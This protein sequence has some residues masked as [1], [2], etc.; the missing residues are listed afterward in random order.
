MLMTAATVAVL[1]Q[2]A[3]CD[4][5]SRPEEPA[6]EVPTE[7]APPDT[8]PNFAGTVSDQNYT[9]GDE[10]KPLTLP[11]ASGGNGSLSYSLT[12]TVPGLLFVQ[13]TRTLGGTPTSSGSYVMTYRSVDGDDNTAEDD[14]AVLMF[15]I[16]VRESTPPDTAPSFGVQTVSDQT[17]TAGTQIDALVLPE[18][19]GGNGSLSYSL[20]PTVPGLLFVQATRTLSGTPTSSGSYVMTYRSVDGDDNTA[21]DDTAVLMF[22]IVVRESTP[23]DTAP[24]FGVQTV[25]DQTYTA[26][27]Q[28]DAL[29]LPEASGGNGSLSYSLTPTVPGLLFVQATRTLS[30]TP[31]S[32]GSYVMTYR[33]VDG[34]DN[35][36]EDDT[37]VLMFMIVVRES[38]PPDTA[39]SFGVQTVSDQ[40]YTAGTQIDALVL[41]EASGGNG[42]LTYSLNTS[43]VPDLVFNK[44][45]RM[46]TGRPIAVGTYAM[47]YR[48]EDADGDAATLNFG[49]TVDAGS[50]P[51]I[52]WTNIWG[53]RISRSNLD[54]SGIEVLIDS[55][56]NVRDPSWI[57]LDVEGGKMYWV[58]SASRGDKVQR[59]NLD[60]SDVEDL[61]QLEHA[62][63]I[64]LD[65]A[66][67]KMYWTAHTKIQRANLDGS[68]VE[69]VVARGGND[70]QGIALDTTSGKMYWTDSSSNKIRRANIDGSGLE[71]LAD[72]DD[73]GGLIWGID[74]DADS[75]KMYW[76]DRYDSV[77]ERANLDGSNVETLVVFPDYDALYPTAIA[78]DVAA[79]K[80]YFAESSRKIQ[81]ANLDGSQLEDVLTQDRFY[82]FALD[83]RDR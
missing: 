42:P 11:A 52:Y 35:T 83:L 4:E 63:G 58:S 17:Y 20:T 62:D 6:R 40:T 60:G 47:R 46:L 72:F 39:P 44:L 36:A 55:D 56:R 65:I 70:L 9:V 78:L 21:E 71:V 8:A 29:V 74:I 31:T 61:V 10:I 64:T 32:S 30:G 16:V 25:S 43:A 28:I 79:E 67:G 77:V 49:I 75:G 80:M 69:D 23:P 45:T 59:A 51:K 38:T 7:P 13:A 68:H 18:A 81:R 76:T 3:A 48:V 66:R 22:M 12:P 2:L 24:S 57:A 82:Y 19:S 50:G 15:M 14:T 27:T 53:D 26:G 1:L 41:P 5:L 73:T 33:S 37:A 34:D 54:G